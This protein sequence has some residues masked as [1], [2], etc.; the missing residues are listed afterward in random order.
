LTS[1]DDFFT[2]MQETA[3]MKNNR[4]QNFFIKYYPISCIVMHF[5]GM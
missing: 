4:I 1:V 2:A 5:S 3:E